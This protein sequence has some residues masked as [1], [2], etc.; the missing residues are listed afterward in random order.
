MVRVAYTL[1]EE[2]MSSTHKTEEKKP[3]NLKFIKKKSKTVIN[4]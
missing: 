3:N 2:V 1:H 4:Y